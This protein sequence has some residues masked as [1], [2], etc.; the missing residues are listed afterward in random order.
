MPQYA[1]IQSHPPGNCPISG[2]GARDWANETLPKSEEL[3]KKMGI[4]M[5]V[6]YMHLDPAHKGLLLLE[7]PS[8]E[9]VRDFLIQGGFFHLLDSEFYFV[10]PIADLLKASAGMPTIFP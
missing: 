9:T 2:K 7:G 5:V 8:G 4:R 6:P 3:A 1:I 10:T